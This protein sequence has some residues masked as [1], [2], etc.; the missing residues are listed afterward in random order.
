MLSRIVGTYVL[1]A[2]LPVLLLA[3]APVTTAR[4]QIVERPNFLWIIAEDLSP[5]LGILGTPEAR[6]PNLDGLAERGMLF[7]RAF[8]PSPVCSPS[9][10]ALVTGVYP[11]AIGAHNHRSHR[12]GDPSPHPWPLPDSVRT[13]M[14]WLRQEGYTTANV[15]HF[16][17][18]AEAAGQPLK[19]SGKT[20]WNFTYRGQPFGTN[21]WS[22][23]KENQPF[24]AQVNFSETHRG[25]A[26]QE[27]QESVRQPADP[28]RV[29]LPPYYPDHPVARREWAEYLNTLQ[30]LDEKVGAVLEQLDAD[31]LAENTIV[32]FLSDHGRAMLR[33]KQ[34][35]YDSGLRIP[36]IVYWPEA[37]TPPAPYAAGTRSARL[38]STLDLTATTMAVAGVP[39][40]EEKTQGRVLFGPE[41]GPERLYVFG[42]RDRGDE[43]VDRMRTVR[44]DRFRYIRNEYPERPYLQTNRYK[45]A[46]YPMLWLLRK[47]DQEGK[48]NAVQA[49]FLGATRPEEELYDLQADPHE[50]VNLADSSAYEEELLQLRGRLDGWLDAVGRVDDEDP[51]VA[52]YYEEAMRQLYDERIEALRKE[53]GVEP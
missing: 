34:W 44:S 26:W 27:A 31:G 28:A 8:T 41:A 14:D 9:R 16:P 39:H 10:S 49:R 5:D 18:G 35:P 17:E 45:Q 43:T 38:V 11:Q 46:N 52:A 36:F 51:D 42:G 3:F 37:L 1:N 29:E 40:P 2:V 22:D 15:V 21:R 33:A 50:T 12:P 48:L 47:L 24:Y 23:L 19:G 6:T 13:V 4:A 20:D 53:W 30:V 25:G 32:V 7:T